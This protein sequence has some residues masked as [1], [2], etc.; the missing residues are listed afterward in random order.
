MANECPVKR[1]YLSARN[2]STSLWQKGQQSIIG[3]NTAMLPVTLPKHTSTLTSPSI[4]FSMPYTCVPLI[5]RTDPSPSSILPWLCS[6]ASWNGDFNWML[7]ALYREE[8]DLGFFATI[9]VSCNSS[10]CCIP[11]TS[12]IC[13]IYSAKTF[14]YKRPAAPRFP[15]TYLTS[16]RLSREREWGPVGRIQL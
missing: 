8:E 2:V 13:Y 14:A 10:S 16:S 11:Q 5:I 7:L 1:I 15:S 12:N 3:R 9:T 6:L 4:F